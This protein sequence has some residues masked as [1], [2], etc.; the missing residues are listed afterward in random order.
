M[1]ALPTKGQRKVWSSVERALDQETCFSPSSALWGTNL[2]KSL[3]FST[4]I[5]WGYPG[6]PFPPSSPKSPDS[7]IRGGQV[8]DMSPLH[9][10]L[11]GGHGSLRG[12]LVSECPWKPG[13]VSFRSYQV[14][15]QLW[16]P[17]L[18]FSQGE[19]SPKGCPES[20]WLARE[21]MAGP[22]GHIG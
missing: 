8:E 1:G 18:F 15:S 9:S 6:C 22:E 13:L 10:C 16:T 19:Y 4:P 21:P 11:V 3:G 5:F 2:D 14:R 17:F 20:P 12:S 7:V